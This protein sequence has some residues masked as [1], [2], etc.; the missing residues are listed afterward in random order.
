MATTTGKQTRTAP[1]SAAPQEAKTEVEE[2]AAPPAKR[3]SGVKILLLLAPLVAAGAGAAWFFLA[4]QPAAAAH[5][6]AGAKTAS[7]KAAST[8]PP[9]FVTLEPFTVNLQHDG[10]AQQYLQVGLSLKVANENVVD[11]V[12]LH[13]PEIRNRVLLLLSSKKAAEVSDSQGKTALSKELMREIAQPLAGLVPADG[14]D[15]VLFTSFVVQ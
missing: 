13:M 11:A 4:D 12:K 3:R 6:P 8:K 1:K 15:S 10:A 2:A 14:L 7:A 5:R 9:L